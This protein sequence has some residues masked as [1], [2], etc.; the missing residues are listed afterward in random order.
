MEISHALTDTYRKLLRVHFLAK[1]HAM[2][3]ME[4]ASAM[5][6]DTFSPVNLHYGTFGERLA[7]RL[8]YVVP[9][10]LPQASIH[11]TFSGGG[12][13]DP[14]TRWTMRPEVA[15]ALVNLRIVPPPRALP[16]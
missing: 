6:W 5:Q 3:T 11:S 15:T 16:G 2:T 8:G 12:P 14:H 4:L 13:E 7:A 10:G 1:G 9:T